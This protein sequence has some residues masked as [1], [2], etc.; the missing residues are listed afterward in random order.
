MDYMLKYTSHVIVLNSLVAIHKS[1]VS[2]SKTRVTTQQQQPPQLQPDG[3]PKTGSV[4]AE[5]KTGE[6]EQEFPVFSC[7]ISVVE[8]KLVVNPNLKVKKEK[9][10][11]VQYTRYNYV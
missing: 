8:Q 9:N 2:R 11:N 7:Q 6:A 3:Q 1:L 5:E 4:N 10:P